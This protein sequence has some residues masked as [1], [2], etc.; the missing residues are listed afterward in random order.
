MALTDHDGLYGTVQFATAA[1]EVGLA[2]VF[3]SELTLNGGTAEPGAADPPGTHLLVLAR[4]P[5]GY[6][7][8]SRAIAQA[9]L[10]VGEK[11]LPRY[12]IEELAASSSGQWLILTGCRKGAVRRALERPGGSRQ[13]AA[14]QLDRLMALFGRDNVA[15]EITNSGDP[16]DPARLA[17]LA[18]LARAAN[19]PLVATSNAHYAYGG[20]FHLA[21]AM[22]AVRARRSL[23]EMDGYLPSGPLAALSS[24][25]QMAARMAL[26]P[27]ALSNAA[28][29]ASQCAFD[30]KLI[31]PQLPP[32][33][34]PPGMSEKS[35]LEEL[36]WRGAL[37][38]YGPRGAA[39]AQAYATLDHELSVIESL[40]FSGYFL[41]MYEVVQ[42]CQEQN[43]LCQGRGS[44]ANSAVC[45]AL[46]ITAI[47]AVRHR[48]LFERFLA[49]ERE[50]YPD[51]DLD[52]ESGRREEVIQHVYQRYGR[53]RAALVG[54][55]ISYRPRLA[56]RDAA[57]ALGYGI[58][59]QDAWAK[60]IERWGHLRH[61]KVS[62]TP[63]GR[64]NAKPVEADD[65]LSGIPSDVLDLA[66]QFMKLP[67][68]LG[69]HPG[70][71]VLADQPVIDICPVQWGRMANRSVL[72]WDKD[73]CAAAGLVK[74]DLLGLGM[75]GAIHLAFD[76]VERLE[77]QHWQ[78]HTLPPECPEV[79]DL[80]CAA[81]TVGVFQVES[82]A[83]MATLPRLQ[84]R[85]FYDIVVEVALIRPG[86]IQGGS[87]HPYIDR[88]RGRAPV[89]FDHELLR[90]VLE[91]TMGVPLFQ[92]QLMQIAIA[93]AGFSPGQAD[94]LRR[95]MG[96]KRSVE[97]MEALKD[98]LMDGMRARS[99][100]DGARSRIYDQLKAFADFGFPESHAFSFALIVYV[101]A[102]LKVFHPAAFYA[103]IL[104]S[105]PMGFYSPQSLV[106]D[107]RR[108]G[109]V[110]K[111][112]D[113][114][115]SRTHASAEVTGPSDRPYS[116]LLR[117]DRRLGVR[118]GLATIR[119]I[120][121]RQAE[122][123][124]A[125]RRQTAFV[126]LTDLAHRC[127]LTAHQMECL[128]T[129]GALS[130]LE[131]DRRRALW[132][133]GA[134]GG[135]TQ[136]P[137]TTPG[138]RAPVLPGMSDEELAQADIW[139]SGVS[140]GEYPTVHLRGALEA[141]GVIPNEQ[142]KDQPDG[143]WLRVAGVVTHRQRP[144]TA[145]GVTFLNLEDETASLNIICTKDVWN[146]Y[147]K[148]ARTASAMVVMGRLERQDGALG[149]KAGHLY[150]LR[151][152]V[153]TKSRDF[154]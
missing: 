87:V 137:G 13:A 71:M 89:T 10:V 111:G 142:V 18:D 136:L 77:G 150:P 17:V 96:S 34:V 6:K 33:N 140:L 106:A 112:P 27:A 92:E 109:L 44:A 133:A 93:A 70:G 43:I 61:G 115:I 82:R 60:Q 80:L 113:V 86:P 124:E 48:L 4:G 139:A 145:G 75:L 12:D 99:I 14:Q 19:L 20:E 8:L 119:G 69:I 104:A 129:A 56:L 72:Q 39:T 146:R 127:A 41:I 152:T 1:R 144:N 134:L 32:A 110:V 83:Q 51:I 31:A 84:P 50:G 67:R 45:Y 102:W 15:V 126:S 40:G 78:M 154:H 5:E 131:P 29:F 132:A 141:A 98:Q 85:Q 73:D 117:G 52:I 23:D 28:R 100:P 2:T 121:T 88:V 58:G 35:W 94:R 63:W 30:L 147:R 54:A 120:G 53:Q 114:Q 107:A 79:Y 143:A 11:G 57:R 38:R 42:F 125:E 116:E 128:A 55:V 25:S 103:A 26:Y 97:A 59:Q 123:I 24:P 47:D 91:R 46:G 16:A 153:P 122:R 130:S 149:I 101:S 66:E 148:T 138:T 105:Q 90:P 65:D 37:A 81:D 68:H 49:P 151:L 7:K 9:Y 135:P 108:H 76:E 3:G 62:Y 95:A 22:S 74:F 36:T 21:S 64:A 118:L